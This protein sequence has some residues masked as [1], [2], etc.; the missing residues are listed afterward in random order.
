MFNLSEEMSTLTKNNYGKDTFCVNTMQMARK[1]HQTNTASSI[2]IDLANSQSNLHMLM[3]FL[4]YLAKNF[5]E[6][7]LGIGEYSGTGKILGQV[8]YLRT[9]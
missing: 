4:P 3:N 6:N 8:F 1:H 2:Q 7:V 5:L 9:F